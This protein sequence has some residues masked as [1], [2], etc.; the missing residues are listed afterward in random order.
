M[1]GA[2]PLTSTISDAPPTSSTRPSIATR[3]PGLTTTLDR[4]RVLNEGIVTSI[5]Y[6]PAVRF[7]TTKSPEE[8]V[9]AGDDLFPRASLTS[10]TVAPGI[11]PPCASFTVPATVPVV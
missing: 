11:T 1:T 10:T 7:G 3:D 6:V 4:F 9:I 5:V 8:F 2:S